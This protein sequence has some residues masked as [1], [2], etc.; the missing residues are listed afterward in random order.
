M[1]KGSA[2]KPTPLRAKRRRAASKG[3]SVL[4]KTLKRELGTSG[5]I[6]SKARF[7]AVMLAA[8]RSGLLSEKGSRIGGRVS[9]ALVRQAKHQTGIEADTELIEFA[10]ATVALEDNFAEAFKESR[11]KVDP[12]L[13]L[14][15]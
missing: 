15:F 8:E 5:L 7:E 1:A 6:A 4:I 3:G 13:K 2:S 11:G 14:G 9:P 10:L 12:A